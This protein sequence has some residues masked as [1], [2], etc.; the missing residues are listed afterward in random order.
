M[1]LSYAMKKGMVGTDQAFGV[2]FRDNT[3]KRHHRSKCCALGAAVLGAG[4]SL[5]WD[6]PLFIDTFMVN[7]IPSIKKMITN[8]VTNKRSNLKHV[9]LQLN[10]EHKWSRTRIINWLRE[11]GL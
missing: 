7:T 9:V 1:K 4:G 11:Q 5:H 10:D 2:M 6:D 8:P 3:D